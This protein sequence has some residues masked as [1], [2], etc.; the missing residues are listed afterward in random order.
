MRVVV[1]GAS[2]GIGSCIVAELLRRGHDVHGLSRGPH[3]LSAP[4]YRHTR[5]DVR[6]AE[7]LVGLMADGGGPADAVVHVAWSTHRNRDADCYAINVGG[8]RAVLDAAER[9]GVSRLVAMSSAMAYGA[10][11]DNPGRLVES[12]PLRPSFPDRDSL[13]KARAEELITNSGVNALLVRAANVLGRES[14]GVTQRRFAAPVTVGVK[15][16]RN[17]V[18]FIHPD[19]LGRFVG[20]AVEHPGWT[21]P[22]NLAAP[23]VI[24]VREVAAILGK[25]YIECNPSVLAAVLGLG[26]NRRLFSIDPRAIESMVYCP[27]VDTTRLSDLGF[28]PAWTASECVTDFRRANRGHIYLGSMRVAVPWRLPWTRVPSPPRDG[29]QR[30][31]A[32]NDGAGG[33]FDTDVDPAW[34]VYTAANTAEAFPGPMTPLSLELSLEA[35]RTTGA[36]SADLL[37]MEG[38]VRRALI[39]EQTG[40]FGHTIYLNLSVLFATTPVLPGAE[41]AAWENLLFGV[42]ST[43]EVPKADMIGQ[44]GMARRLPRMVAVIAGAT[45]ETRRMD[46]EAR[47]Q[48]R[49]AAYYAGLT[50]EKLQCQ[51]RCTRDEV[52]NAWAVAGLASLAVVPIVA[53]IEK[54]AGK[55]F[56]TQFRGGTESLVSAGLIRGAHELSELACA[57]ASIATILAEPD[58]CVALNRLEAEH[59]R[60]AARLHG[61]I[62]EY[63]HRG[64]GETELINPVFADS[65]ARLLD[66]VAKLTR[67]AERTVQPMPPAG[68][69][70]RLL[71]RLG[72]GFQQSR[73]RARD[74]AV[75]HTHCY[76]LITREIG[77]RLAR[78]GVIQHPDDVFYLIRDE[79]LQ[80]PA[81]VRRRVA[82]R[83]AEQARLE[84]HRPPMNFV[85]R[86]ELRA[87]DFTEAAAGESLSGIPV[88]A[89]IAKGRV[90]VLTADLT[91]ELQPDEVLVTEF[92]DIGWTPFFA[93]AA[94]VVVDT[95]AEMSHAAVVARE[96]GIPC[97][98]GSIVGSRVLRTGHL[99]EVDGSSGRVTRV[100]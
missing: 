69:K 53:I 78:E 85:E 95:G 63:G 54:Q 56:A 83:Q 55:R 73:E 12:D 6:D 40:S 89:G 30:R 11:A 62:A 22:V 10:H 88:S 64:P 19:D 59:P 84:K 43:A 23:D 71:A 45:S 41:P 60:F 96:F 51:L 57:D 38:E 76:R 86:W 39:E 20:D 34:S 47:R 48:Q 74:A 2:G 33:E 93:H 82:R 9:A 28:V 13:H 52:V 26:W 15:G 29:P 79:L 32:N 72:A 5:A 65:P 98:V 70:L 81:D 36:L 17:I 49:D 66:V 3:S 16:G 21:G 1:T 42:G 35:G 100:E 94:A 91:S 92:T 80:P 37:Q 8:T 97:V 31:P 61:V 18:Q 99:V 87:E 58:P 77:S 67:T 7:A 25:R 24:A 75:R 90:R 46:R 50:D 44:W 14:A 4:T 68:P 27:L